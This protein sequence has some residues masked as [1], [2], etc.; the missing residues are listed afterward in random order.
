[1][2]AFIFFN[3][4]LF[5]L[6]LVAHT[7]IKESLLRGVA[8]IQVL[9]GAR[10]CGE[11][12]T[13]TLKLVVRARDAVLHRYVPPNKFASFFL[14]ANLWLP[15]QSIHGSCCFFVKVFVHGGYLLKPNNIAGKTQ[16]I[17]LAFEDTSFIE[18]E[19]KPARA[20]LL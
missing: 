11:L 20:L 4:D 8:Q 9:I 12:P 2:E 3:A 13:T 7:E 17:N 6:R 19:A 15:R 1:M 5:A 10:Q 18:K 14:L 16:L